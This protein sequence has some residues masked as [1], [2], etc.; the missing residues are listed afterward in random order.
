MWILKTQ[1]CSV[2]DTGIFLH[3]QRG[4]TLSRFV[5]YTSAPKPL[6]KGGVGYHQKQ[7][8]AKAIYLK[9]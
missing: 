2:I 3:T 4:A 6:P 9:F 5:T 1:V 8:D 7:T